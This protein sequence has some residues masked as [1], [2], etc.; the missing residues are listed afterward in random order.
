MIYQSNE[1]A[2]MESKNLDVILQNRVAGVIASVANTGYNEEKFIQLEKSGVPVVFFD[3]CFDS[4]H[5]SKILI[6]N[7]KGAFDATDFLIRK[8]HKKIGFYHGYKENPVFKERHRGFINA[9]SKHKIDKNDQYIFFGGTGLEDGIELARNFSENSTGIE[10]LLC[11][12][13]MVALGVISGS[14]GLGIKIPEDLALIGFDNEPAGRIIR[15]SLTTVS[16]PVDMIGKSAFELLLTRMNDQSTQ[17][18]DKVLLD[19][20]LIKRKSA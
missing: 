16:Q 9:L 7:Y 6:N 14:R 17:T 10:A 19:M 2:G 4:E 1:E 13:D 5:F 3:R 18:N 20:E 12:V 11:C 15:P 8:G